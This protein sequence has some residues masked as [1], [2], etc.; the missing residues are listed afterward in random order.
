MM[1]LQN[2]RKLEIH[3]KLPEMLSLTRLGLKLKGL[4]SSLK[5]AGQPAVSPVPKRREISYLLSLELIKANRCLE[6]KL[7]TQAR[8]ETELRQKNAELHQALEKEKKLNDL[9]TKLLS[10]ASHEF[11]T[12]LTTVMMAADM[13]ETFGNSL[14]SRQKVSFLGRIKVATELMTE[15]MN[16]ILQYNRIDAGL[17]TLASK[18]IDLRQF[19][20]ELID[21][22]RLI[23]DHEHNIAFK[24]Q[25][26]SGGAVFNA[27]PL[28]LR[29]IINNLLSNAV[30]YSPRGGRVNLILKLSDKKVIFQVEDQGMGI[31]EEEINCLF[32]AFQRGSNVRNIQGTGLGLAIVKKYVDLYEGDIRVESEINRGSTFTVTLPLT[33]CSMK[34]LSP[35]NLK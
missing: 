27:D 7:K 31:P 32:E 24:V 20:T 13:L 17:E 19:C 22:I 11:R 2:S 5:A 18:E 33:R 14:T 25:Q 34:Q 35:S 16:E 1:N 12:P 23:S 28:V 15:L 26:N 30:K 4:V 6:E 21:E 8:I 9:K 3:A 29:Q 10:M